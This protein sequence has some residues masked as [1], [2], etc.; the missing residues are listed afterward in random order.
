[1]S[2]RG[3]AAAIAV[4]RERKRKRT[5]EA[6]DNNTITPSATPSAPSATSSITKLQLE[7]EDDGDSKP[8]TIAVR[9]RRTPRIL[10]TPIVASGS[11]K[12]ASVETLVTALRQGFD[13]LAIAKMYL[14]ETINKAR[15]KMLDFF[16]TFNYQC[17]Y[18]QKFKDPNEVA[19]FATG[20]FEYRLRFLGII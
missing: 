19:M 17:F 10:A 20:I 2:S 16:L 6:G 18:L 13:R 9:S 8:G 4:V 11:K 1:M 7:E 5:I 15:T 3:I 14:I 12:P